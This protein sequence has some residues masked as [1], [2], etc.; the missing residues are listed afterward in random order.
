MSKHVKKVGMAHLAPLFSEVIESGKTVKFK[1]VGNSMYPMLRNEVDS[2]VLGS[3]EKLSKHDIP[4]YRRKNG[5]YILHRIVK[6]E[7]GSFSCAGDNQLEIEHP[8]TKE[9]IIGKVV[10]FYRRDKYISCNNFIYRCYSF[11]WINFKFVRP[12]FFILRKLRRRK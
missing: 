4:F 9:Q 7:S 3:A 5:E 8:V 2:V 12:V 11:L 1:V 10:G 6:A